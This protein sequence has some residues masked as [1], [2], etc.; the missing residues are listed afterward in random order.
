MVVYAFPYRR[1]R[2]WIQMAARPP[3]NEQPLAVNVLEEDEAFIV[4]ALTP[5]LSSENIQIQILDDIITIEG[6]FPERE[7]NYLVQ[8]LP[9][10]VFRRS[11]RLPAAVEADKV[12]AHLEA[13]VLTL[14]LPKSEAARA[15]SVPI[16]AI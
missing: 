4:Q 2:R 1:A 3:E 11:L 16:R 9:G 6:R 8:E 12:E 14:R 5:G 7:G 10:G 15:K 13:G